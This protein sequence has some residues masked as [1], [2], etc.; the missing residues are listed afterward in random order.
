VSGQASGQGLSLRNALQ[1]VDLGEGV[2]KLRLE[3]SHAHLDTLR[4][5][6][7]RAGSRPPARPTWANT[8]RRNWRLPRSISAPSAGWTAASWPAARPA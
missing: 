8:R 5:A 2:L 4:C 3:G 6:A 7:A 1:G